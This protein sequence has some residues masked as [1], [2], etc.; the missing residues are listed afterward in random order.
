[1]AVF[2]VEAD[3]DQVDYDQAD[4]RLAACACT[5]DEP[6]TSPRHAQGRAREEFQSCFSVMQPSVVQVQ[7]HVSW[8]WYWQEFQVTPYRLGR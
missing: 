8:Q 6:K 2:A 5:Q 3:Y 7:V 1:M 4:L